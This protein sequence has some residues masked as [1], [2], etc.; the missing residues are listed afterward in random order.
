MQAEGVGWD[1]EAT[2]AWERVPEGGW[3][4][5]ESASAPVHLPGLSWAASS[6]DG[7]RGGLR[8]PLPPKACWGMLKSCLSATGYIGSRRR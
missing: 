3:G 1:A 4:R 8:A 6:G 7:E 5:E 2:P